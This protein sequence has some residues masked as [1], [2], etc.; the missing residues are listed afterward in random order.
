MKTDTIS[1]RVDSSV[2][3]QVEA[4]LEVLGITTADAIN[5][6]LKQIILRRGLPIEV[7]LP[8]IPFAEAEKI[9]LEKIKKA[10]QSIANNNWVPINEIRAKQ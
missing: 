9:I 4:I 1:M 2:K 5:M 8:E 6:F 7:K 10:E 3:Q